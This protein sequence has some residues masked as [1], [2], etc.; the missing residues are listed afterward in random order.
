MFG[1]CNGLTLDV[2]CNFQG[3]AGVVHRFSEPADISLS[4]L[5][6]VMR[7]ALSVALALYVTLH[8]ARLSTLSFWTPWSLRPWRPD[9]GTTNTVT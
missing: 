7:A 5:R 1:S 6:A 4:V 3:D 9:D 2:V 8:V